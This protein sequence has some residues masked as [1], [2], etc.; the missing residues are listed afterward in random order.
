MRRGKSERHRERS[1]EGEN[2]RETELRPAGGRTRE[3]RGRTR[4]SEREKRSGVRERM[5]NA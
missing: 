2:L 1:L 5:M 4:E 3:L